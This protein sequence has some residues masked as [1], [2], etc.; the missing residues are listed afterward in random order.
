MKQMKKWQWAFV[1]FLV[2]I[3]LASIVADFTASHDSH[4]STDTHAT[5][6]EEAH[7]TEEV[8]H[9]AEAH[10][11]E[12]HHKAEGTNHDTDAHHAE[13][14]HAAKADAHGGSHWWSF[15]TFWIWFGAFG[16]FVITIFAKKIL[17]PIIYKKE[18]FYNE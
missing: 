7:K 17:G 8:Q 15:K 6:A 13:V 3:T 18:D 4:N 9:T 11:T 12:G 2:I 5:Q 1:A 16:T 10:E 14:A